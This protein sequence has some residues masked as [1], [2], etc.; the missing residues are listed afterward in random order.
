MIRM[1]EIASG[2]LEGRPKERKLN[3]TFHG[4]RVPRPAL[5][6]CLAREMYSRFWDGEDEVGMVP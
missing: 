1:R 4:W 2:K 3:M 6:R 5:I